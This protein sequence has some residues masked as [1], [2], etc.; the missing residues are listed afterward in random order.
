MASL[1]LIIMNT[2]TQTQGDVLELVEQPPV[3]HQ[4]PAVIASQAVQ[5]A[6]NAGI[7][8][9]D[10]L[11]IAMESGD[12]D[13][14]R[15]ERLMAMD[16]RYRELQEVDRQRAAKLAFDAAFAKFRGENII[17]PKTKHVDRGSG[18]SFMQ[19][20]YDQACLRLSPALA[21]H[22]FSFRHKM[23]FNSKRQ[24]IDG[25]EVDVPWVWVVCLL[26][27]KDGYT[28]ELELEGPPGDTKANTDVQNM[29]VTASF[30]KRQSLLAITGTATG[31][32][33]DESRFRKSEQSEAAA[34][35]NDALRKAGKAAAVSGMK[36][37]TTWWGSLTD[38]QRADMSKDFGAM[39]KDARA[40]D[41]GG[42]K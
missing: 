14:D 19:A 9:A 5:A 37:L 35:E 34:T 25:V 23:T 20:E 8:P 3:S 33:D 24:M 26:T 21:K 7:T 18:G 28:D 39:R 17:I 2:A 32:E 40:V 11:R 12:K 42:A 27:H 10:L 31:G 29:Q 13:I 41:E 16:L 15:L 22:G 30:F 1:Q 6:S 36:V 4:A 38:K